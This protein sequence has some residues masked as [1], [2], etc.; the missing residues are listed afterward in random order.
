MAL[1]GRNGT[2][3]STLLRLIAG[4][5]QPDAGSLRLQTAGR[6]GVVAQEAPGGMTTPLE[7]VLAADAER[8]SLLEEAR[9]ATDPH[10]IGEIH[11]RLAEIRSDAAPARAARILPC[12]RSRAVGECASPW[13]RFC[14][15][16]RISCFSTSRRT[17]ST[18]RRR[19]GSR[20][21]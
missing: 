20:T 15:W 21:I 1:I 11:N 3:K 10:R 17:I 16:S 4:D 6:I 7:A 8:S 12:P 19:C 18:S 13:R 14:S 5:I 9:F 2:G